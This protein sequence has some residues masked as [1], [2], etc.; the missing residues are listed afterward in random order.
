MENKTY[1]EVIGS[2]SAPFIN[3]LAQECGIATNYHGITH[4]SLPNYL[5][6]TGGSTFGVADD[7][8]PD[9]HPI[10]S[11]SLF[12][13]LDRAGLSWRSYEESMPENC[14]L[15]A[16]GRYSPKHNPA[17]YYTNLRA[18]CD[19]HDVP[20]NGPLSQDLATGSLPSFSFVTPNL[21]HDTHDC[22]VRAGDSWLAPLL[23]EIVAARNYRSGDT[24]VVVTWDE[25]VGADNKIP[26]VVVAPSVRPG[27][28]VSMPLDHYALLGATE[29]LFGL[30]RLGNAKA[31]PSMATAFN[32][33]R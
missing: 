3:A 22:S 20:L 11:E 21:C 19:A 32:L 8:G 17:A 7:D 26:T 23:K 27:M 10:S 33:I 9:A 12:G 5:A 31:A 18:S 25:G 24:V 6:A 29:S 1:G 4:P 16:S 15:S 30:D 2:D 14:D 28:R 13:Q